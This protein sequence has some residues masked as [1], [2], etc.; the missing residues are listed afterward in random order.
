MRFSLLEDERNIYMKY[1]GMSLPRH[2][3]YPTVPFWE[4]PFDKEVLAKF[5]FQID[6]KKRIFS[7]YIHIPYCKKL[8]FYCSC[9]KE[10]IDPIRGLKSDPREKFLSTLEKEINFVFKE[11]QEK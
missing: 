6:E 8:C 11:A 10:I 5:L 7:L 4:S 1:A 2:T 9:N 3:S